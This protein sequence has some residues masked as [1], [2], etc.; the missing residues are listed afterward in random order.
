MGNLEELAAAT[1]DHSNQKRG[2]SC[3]AQGC[4]HLMRS[5]SCKLYRAVSSLHIASANGRTTK[6]DSDK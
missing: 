2:V 3:D 1:C 6:G 5:C 4:Q